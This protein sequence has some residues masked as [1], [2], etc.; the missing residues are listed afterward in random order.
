MRTTSKV[1][2]ELFI[3][4]TIWNLE[5]NKFIY[6]KLCHHWTDTLTPATCV[7]VHTGTYCTITYMCIVTVHTYVIVQYV[8]VCTCTCKVLY[9]YILYVL[10]VYSTYKVL[11][12]VT[13]CMYICVYSTCKVLCTLHR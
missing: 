5:S 11:C 6:N 7:Q 10:C 13:Y 9:R 8:P 4:S 3:P 1:S 2:D 12:T